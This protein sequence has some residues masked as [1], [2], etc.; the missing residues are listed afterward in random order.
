MMMML[1]IMILIDRRFSHAQITDDEDDDDVTVFQGRPGIRGMTGEPG[2]RGSPGANVS[3]HST[4]SSSLDSADARSDDDDDDDDDR[5]NCCVI[6]ENNN[7]QCTARHLRP[8]SAQRS[9]GCCHVA[10]SSE[11]CRL[12]DFYYVLVSDFACGQFHPPN[13]QVS[14]IYDPCS[15]LQDDGCSG[16]LTNTQTE[17][18]QSS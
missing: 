14:V 17:K 7:K 5:A 1:I 4:R 10:S 18:K 8:D 6:R 2:L 11:A 15:E 9:A 16:N 3:H 12:S 13:Q